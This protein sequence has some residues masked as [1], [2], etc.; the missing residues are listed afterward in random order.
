MNILIQR[1]IVFL[2]ITLFAMGKI[3]LNE[4][5]ELLQQ[6]EET[7]IR[8]FFFFHLMWGFVPRRKYLLY[9]LSGIKWFVQNTDASSYNHCIILL[10]LICFIFILSCSWEH[11][12][13]KSSHKNKVEK[14]LRLWNN[15]GFSGEIIFMF[16][17]TWCSWS[18]K[19]VWPSVKFEIIFSWDLQFSN[20]LYLFSIIFTLR[21]VYLMFI[22]IGIR[23]NRICFIF[24][25]ALASIY[26]SFQ[27]FD[28]TSLCIHINIA[29][30]DMLQCFIGLRLILRLIAIFVCS[31]KVFKKLF[32]KSHHIGFEVS[33][34]YWLLFDIVWVFLLVIIPWWGGKVI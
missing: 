32:S 27:A 34:W 2:S 12:L 8:K 19:G 33:S 23:K 17:F 4:S 11:Y 24:G 13:E 30:F 15:C 20:T 16:I 10:M 9:L 26:L 25:V 5:P 14:D 1:V 22:R 18:I 29:D 31:L 3:L 6:I 21:W 28:Y 7:F